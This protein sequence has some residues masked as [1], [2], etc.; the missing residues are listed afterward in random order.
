MYLDFARESKKT[1]EQESYDYTNCNGCSWYSHQKIGT[2]TGGLGNNG[3]AGDCPNYS[4][5]EI[6]QN[7]ETSPGDLR[8]LTVTHSR[9]K[10]SANA[11]MKNVQGVK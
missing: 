8:R 4:I 10:Q 6:G 9:E 7:P 3:T 1:V 2:M 5:V 11:D